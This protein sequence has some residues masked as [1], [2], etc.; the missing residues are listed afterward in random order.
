MSRERLLE[1]FLRYVRVETTS[2][3]DSSAIPTTPGQMRLGELI[4]AEL[5][6]I[7]LVD[8]EQAATGPIYATVPGTATVSKTIPAL[9]F[10][11]H[12]DTSP[13]AS[14]KNVNPQ[15]IRSYQGGDIVL[16]HRAPDGD[17]NPLTITV[18]QNP[19]L[20]TM[21]GKTIIT[22]D[23][24]TLLGGDDKAGVAVI[25]EAAQRLLEDR[26]RK[27]GPV[28]VL[29]TC[30]EEIGRAVAQVDL[31]RL[32]AAAA[33]TLDGEGTGTIDV[34]TFSADQAT[35]RFH[36]INI[37]PS[38][39]AG[40]M[41]NSLR[42]LGTFLSLLPPEM[43]PERTT[44][45]DGFVHPYHLKESGVD[46]VELR[47]LLRDFTEPGLRSQEA[48][49]RKIASD[50]EQAHPGLR[51]TIDVEKQYRNLADGLAARPEVVACA[52]AAAERL[53]RA[54]K[55]G[56]VR[57]GTDGSQLTERGL[58]TPNLS[59][60]Q[61]NPHSPLEFACLDEMEDAVELILEIVTVWAD[62]HHAG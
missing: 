31:T 52:E 57:G 53:G 34:A 28:R 40:R 23:G 27:T 50:V 3:A 22:T 61:H 55:R 4:A 21:I 1:R 10:N 36:G 7:G 26:G 32:D 42:G 56:S 35:V 60:G 58:P 54:L 19:A 13:E 62:H 2:D 24:T 6:E 59:T 33:F 44:G 8:V 43:S 17:Q 47:V 18:E 41:V 12:L 14:G 20:N 30:D 25:I 16:A 15:I 11:S 46:H 51:V 49:L 48:I 37:H 29:L 9:A 38:I 5:L 45:T 39:A